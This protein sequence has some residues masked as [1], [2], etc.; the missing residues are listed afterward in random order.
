M[1]DAPEERRASEKNA[2]NDRLALYM[3]PL[4]PRVVRTGLPL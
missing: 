4:S 3:M 2:E 1:P